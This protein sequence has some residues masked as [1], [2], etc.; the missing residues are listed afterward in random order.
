MSLPPEVLALLGDDATPE[1]VAYGFARLSNQE[2]AA[3]ADQEFVEFA[4]L[5]AAASFDYA[6]AAAAIREC[7]ASREANA[8]VSEIPGDLEKVDLTQAA[9]GA[10]MQD[11]D[12][13]RNRRNP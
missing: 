1:K 8:A 6:L 2:L 4:R 9:L 5:H 11:Y 12:A 3:V 7:E 13:L 10:A